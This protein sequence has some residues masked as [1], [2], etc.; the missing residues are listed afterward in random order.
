M[1]LV[2]KPVYF[3]NRV[4]KDIF[5]LDLK[6][7]KKTK[8]SNNRMFVHGVMVTDMMNRH[9]V[10]HYCEMVPSLWLSGWWAH[11]ETCPRSV[12]LKAIQADSPNAIPSL[13]I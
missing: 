13:R 6:K 2:S 8:G 11:T 12:A 4:G 7:K 1:E 5:S 9:D 3:W 10:P